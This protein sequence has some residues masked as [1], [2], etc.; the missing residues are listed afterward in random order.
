MENSTK[1]QIF[2][3]HYAGGDRNSFRLI[4]EKLEFF[5]QVETPE[6]P[7]RGERMEE[8]FLTSKKEA[9]EDIIKQIKKARKNVPYIFYGHSMGAVLGL[10]VCKAMEENGDPPIYFVPTGYHGPNN[11]NKPPIANLPKTEF[12]NEVRKLGGLSDEI[13]QYEELLDFFEPILRSDFALLENK[14]NLQF[15]GKIKTPIYA[16]M[17]EDEQYASEINNW[18]NYT[19]ANCTCELLPGDHFFIN[20]N[21]DAIANRIN[22]L[23]PLNEILR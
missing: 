9:V 13:M 14:N 3:L 4:K 18:R 19:L 23:L 21:D 10:D 8:K 7:G 22:S 5:F 6:L 11:K 16:I 15:L 12:F 17:G 2:L 20:Q 1:P